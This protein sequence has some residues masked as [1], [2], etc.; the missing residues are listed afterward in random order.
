MRRCRE[1]P[2]G[3]SLKWGVASNGE[4]SFAA[5][6]IAIQSV[7]GEIIDSVG[8]AARKKLTVWFSVPSVIAFAHRMRR[9]Q[10]NNLPSLRLGLFC[11]EA[12][13]ASIAEI[14]GK[15]APNSRIFNLYGPTEA[16]ITILFHELEAG[17]TENIAPIG[18]VFPGS[19]MTIRNEQS[20]AVKKGEAGE[21]LLGGGQVALGYLNS[22]SQTEAR[23]V[24]LPDT[25]EKLWYRT[26]DLTRED[27]AG[28]VH[29]LGRI[30][31]QVK[32]N[33]NR[34]ELLEVEAVLR[35]ASGI[36]D[37]A[38]VLVKDKRSQL[39]S[40]V[41]FVCGSELDYDKIIKECGRVLPTFACPR[42]II[43]IQKIPLNVNGKVDRKA[44]AVLGD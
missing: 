24:R 19:S 12:L 15:S 5:G 13:P 40:L 7:L 20:S 17:Q 2:S 27:E 35:R 36:Q 3:E 6:R 38:V 32:I 30:D 11:G 1:F 14:W 28:V 37:V 10:E 21:L 18:K 39:D 16:T 29:F 9:M 4:G 41:G 34:I 31:E 33:G 22:Q 43:P 23:F 8:F 44:L 25:A 26:G 42:K